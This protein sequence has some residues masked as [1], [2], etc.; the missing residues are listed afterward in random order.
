MARPADSMDVDDAS[1]S[2][3]AAAG[4]EPQKYNSTSSIYINSTITRPD[5]DEIIFCVAIV[6][7]D[8]IEQGEE[9]S[10]EERSRFPY[11]SEENNPLYAV[12]SA[13]AHDDLNQKQ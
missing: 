9:L 4:K 8:R 3:A 2:D 11:F 10:G 5:I 6:I 12:P 1:S 7:H 13:S